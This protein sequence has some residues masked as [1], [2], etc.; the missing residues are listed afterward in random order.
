MN[1]APDLPDMHECELVGRLQMASAIDELDRYLECYQRGDPRR[2][3]LL[4]SLV[5]VDYCGLRELAETIADAEGSAILGTVWDSMF[6]SER[7]WCMELLKFDKQFHDWKHYDAR[8]KAYRQKFRR[9]VRYALDVIAEAD[10]Y[11]AGRA[12]A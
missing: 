1:A 6:S 10:E 9:A 2:I 5:L 8:C 12:A 7:V 3:T 11:L 4:Q